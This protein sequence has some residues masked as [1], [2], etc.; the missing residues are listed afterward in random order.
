MEAAPQKTTAQVALNVA[1]PAT[2]QVDAKVDT[3]TPAKTVSSV[4]DMAQRAKAAVMS[5]ASND[6]P[7]M[8]EKLWGKQPAQGSLLS[9]ASADAS[10]TG[11]IIETRAQNPMLGGSPP[12]DKQTAVYD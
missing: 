9:Y 5:I 10:V 2:K 12:Y 11:S 6:K 8:V 3:K 4:R 1:A 7:T